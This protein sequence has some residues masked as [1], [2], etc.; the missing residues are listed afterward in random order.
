M[1]TASSNCTTCH[2]WIRNSTGT[3]LCATWRYNKQP[4]NKT[5][6]PKYLTTAMPFPVWSYHPHVSWYPSSWS[7][8]TEHQC[9]KWNSFCSRLEE[10]RRATKAKPGCSSWKLHIFQLVLSIFSKLPGYPSKF[11]TDTRI[12]IIFVNCYG[13]LSLHATKSSQSTP[14][15]ATNDRPLPQLCYTPTP[16]TIDYI[17]SYSELRGNL[18]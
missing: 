6:L 1:N 13:L 7:T 9:K 18:T 3:T 11:F 12:S 10:I 4:I 16:A 15:A 5:C 8:T 17:F 2:C 14:V